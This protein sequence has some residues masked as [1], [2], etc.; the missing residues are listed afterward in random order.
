MRNVSNEFKRVMEGRRDFYCTAEITFQDGTVRPLGKDDFALSGNQYVEGTGGIPFPIGIVATKQATVTINNYD[1]RWSAFDFQW[2]KIFLRLCLDLDGGGTE[3][4]NMGHFTVITPESYGTT[5][6]ITAMDDSYKLDRGYDTD[7]P[8]PASLGTA[9]RD[10]CHTCGVTLLTQSFDGSSF[11][12]QKKPEGITHRQFVGLCAMVAGGNAKFDVYNRLKVMPYDLSWFSRP[13][14]DGGYFDKGGS[15][16]FASGDSADGGPFRPWASGDPADGGSFGD[17]DNIHVLYAFKSGLQIATDDVV[18]TGVRLKADDTEWLYGE[19]GYVISVENQL[20]YGQEYQVTRMVAEKI[21]GLRFR[22]FSGDHVAY[23]LAEFGDLAILVGRKGNMYQTFLTDVDF[24]YCGLTT[25]KCS[26]DSPIRNSSRY[27][28]EAAKAVVEAKK[29]VE[30]EKTDRERAIEELGMELAHSSG[31]YMTQDVQ[32]DGSTVY[33]MH[34]KATLGES[35]IVWKLTAEAFGISTDGGETYPYGLDATG[36]AILD[37]IY[38]IGISCDHLTT[39]AF[40]IRKDGKVMV[41]MDKDTGQ[42]VLRP[43]VFELS[44]G[45]T[46]GSIATGKA[47]ESLG[48]FI[49]GVYDPGIASLQAQ[50]DGQIETWYYDYQPTLSNAPASSWATEADRARHEGD[51]FYWKSKGYSYRFFKDG[52]AWKW[53]LITDSDITKALAAAANAQDTADN[54]RR[55]FVATPNPPY[56][57]GDLWVQGSGGDIL[58]AKVSRQSGT[59]VTSDWVKASKYTDD[60]ALD[61]FINGEFQE[62]IS[63]LQAQSDKKAETWYQ[64]TDPSSS[65]TTAAL[66]KEHIGDIWFNSTATVQKS[67]RWDGAGWVEMKTTPPPDVFDEIDGK[68][69]IFI[70]IPKPPY[71]IGD[72]WLDSKAS[73]IMTCVRARASGSYVASD[74]QKR[75]KYIDQEAADNAAKDAVDGQTQEDI[76]N[77]LTNNGDIKGIYKDGN[78]IY[79]N[80]TYIKTGNLS[81][82]RIKGGVLALGGEN[83]QNGSMKVLNGDG[84]AVGSWTNNGATFVTLNDDGT[85]SS[86]FFISGSKIVSM[87]GD[88]EEYGRI[89]YAP[90][91]SMFG[92]GINVTSKYGGVI[93]TVNTSSKGVVPVW[94]NVLSI[95]SEELKAQKGFKHNI[96][97]HKTPYSPGL[98]SAGT[99]KTRDTVTEDIRVSGGAFFDGEGVYMDSLPISTGTN[100]LSIRNNGA[101]HMEVVRQSSSSERYKVI[102]RGM[103]GQDTER[104]YHINPVWARYKEGYLDGGDCRDAISYPM[105]IAEN[106]Y[107][108]F[109]HAVDFD[110]DG[111]PEN[112]NERVMVPAMFQ[113]IKSQ[114]EMIGRLEKRVVALEE[115]MEGGL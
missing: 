96:V 94:A 11:I 71:D 106:V 16:A 77:K 103:S 1:D 31:L 69:Q 38:A 6:T 49:S 17:R 52:G 85:P 3:S 83:N 34:D 74:W 58:R 98:E 111:M 13:G 67:Y 22:P 41:L 29:L 28:S 50:I 72:L 107:E 92:N 2:A 105:F 42:V 27:T 101:G 73:D 26:A 76:F 60:S 81:A 10:S 14:K 15:G 63:D 62:S 21:V 90:E 36:L 68:A 8:Y 46:I 5:I 59:Y 19:E 53:Q 64:P 78:E 99:V 18:I 102:E 45:D 35:M 89:S 100:Y 110:E 20:A 4:I 25:L 55:V 75:N 79:F 9:L 12:I 88:R 56:D 87:N 54:K 114:K 24:T 95:Y 109:P 47:Q 33:Y 104:L 66:K 44:N 48:D 51:L 40:E 37:R 93:F 84:D 86:S 80:A 32:Q 57:V 23:P 82:S 97:F 112:W 7:L 39:G 115:A 43:D 65:W 61:G 108:Y 70:S 91:N 30:R 113:M